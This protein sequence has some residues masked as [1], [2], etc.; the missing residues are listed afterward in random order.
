MRA[1]EF[2]PRAQ[3]LRD[4]SGDRASV[5]PEGLPRRVT[6]RRQAA[7]NR[8]AE[9]CRRSPES[10]QHYGS[11]IERT[12]ND[13]WILEGTEVVIHLNLAPK[14]WRSREERVDSGPAPRGIRCV[15]AIRVRWLVT[16]VVFPTERL[17]ARPSHILMSVKEGE[18]MQKL[19]AY[20]ARPV[21][22][23]VDRESARF[24]LR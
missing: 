11:P 21:C 7:R 13:I 22:R 12:G 19:V 4:R 16:C 9:S 24:R 20:N 2:D 23:Q 10:V 3:R 6:R 14:I 17:F 1:V 15:G 5:A 8:S 18:R